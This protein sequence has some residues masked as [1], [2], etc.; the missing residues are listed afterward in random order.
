MANPRAGKTCYLQKPILRKM[1]PLAWFWL[2]TAIGMQAHAASPEMRTFTID[3]PYHVLRFALPEEMAREMSPL[4]VEKRFDPSEPGI[5]ESGFRV[6]ANKLYDFNGPF[7]VGAYGSLGFNVS[8]IKRHPEYDGAIG[9]IDG[10][11][12]YIRW[13]TG[14]GM[15]EFGYDLA[16]LNGIPCVRRSYDTFAHPRQGDTTRALEVFSYP[17]DDD[18]FLEVGCS[19]TEWVPKSAKKW[20]KKAEAMREAINAT[21]ILEPRE[22]IDGERREGA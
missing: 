14:E 18:M 16:E 7:W 10:L 21:I 8:V 15:G 22:A 11:N 19:I 17:L 9:T 5:L 12:A 4:Q 6:I 13:W 3:L 1:A 2:A 20:K